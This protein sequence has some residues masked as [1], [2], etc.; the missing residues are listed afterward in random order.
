MEG[1]L[2]RPAAITRRYRVPSASA[3]RTLPLVTP[4]T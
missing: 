2:T 4:E 3:R 1:E